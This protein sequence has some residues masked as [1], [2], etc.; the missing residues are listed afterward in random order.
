[1][2]LPPGL[3]QMWTALSSSTNPLELAMSLVVLRQL[4]D[5]TAPDVAGHNPRTLVSDAPDW[6]QIADDPD[7]PA[8]LDATAARFNE[9]IGEPLLETG[10]AAIRQRAVKEAFDGVNK[11]NVEECSSGGD[12]LG[13]LLQQVRSAG[14]GK[15]AFYTPFQISHMMARMVGVGPG[16]EL[17]DPAC[18]TGR[19]LLAG[20]QACRDHHHGGEPLLSGMDID[21]HAI[22]ACKLNLLL[23]GYQHGTHAIEQ[24]N[25]LLA[26]SHAPIAPAGAR[27]ARPANRRPATARGRKPHH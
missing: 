6:A 16:D 26:P 10:F 14:A 1:M 23:A 3:S 19:M 27:P 11:W 24:G 7:L 25:A 13:E 12:M 18:G 8:I 17:T 2:R 22:R 15:G 20:L 9:L 4:L 5:P 21:P